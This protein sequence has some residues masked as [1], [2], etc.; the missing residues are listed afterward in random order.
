MEEEEEP[1][2]G[3]HVDMKIRDNV[4]LDH[5]VSSKCGQK[6]LEYGYI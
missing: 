2:S 5:N 6:L 1:L 3:F 4:G